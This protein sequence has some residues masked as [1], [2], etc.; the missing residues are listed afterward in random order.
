M[1]YAKSS[2]GV[3]GAAGL[4]FK[5]PTGKR[6]VVALLLAPLLNNSSVYCQKPV[7]DNPAPVATLSLG[8]YYAIVIGN[9][10]YRYLTKLQ[11]AVNDATSMAKLLQE[12]YG[13]QERKL[14]LNATRNDIF[15]A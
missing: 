2:I 4:M 13:F 10:N 9:N 11:T 5:S 7:K 12:Q 15:T 14:L 6:F 1:G 3:R 8:P